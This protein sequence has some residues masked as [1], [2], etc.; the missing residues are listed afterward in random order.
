MNKKGNQSISLKSP[1]D[2]AKEWGIKL[3]NNLTFE[4]RII[5]PPKLYFNNIIFQIHEQ[6]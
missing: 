5:S 1:Q 2:L 6:K 3:G 4:G